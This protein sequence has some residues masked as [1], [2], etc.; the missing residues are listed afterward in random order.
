MLK[1]CSFLL[2]VSLAHGAAW[3]EPAYL[4]CQFISKDG[5]PFPVQ[6]TADESAG[7]VSLFMP[8]TGNTQKMTAAFTSDKVIFHD[9]LMVYALNRVSLVIARVIR[10]LNET[11]DGTCKLKEVPKRAF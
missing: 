11:E 10:I 1:Y 4:D 7:T 5:S 2:A 8:T 9:D 3:A 6:I